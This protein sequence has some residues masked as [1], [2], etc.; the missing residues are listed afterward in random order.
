MISMQ[1]ATFPDAKMPRMSILWN[2]FFSLGTH[3]FNGCWCSC[4]GW[5]ESVN[6]NDKGKLMSYNAIIFSS[7]WTDDDNGYPEMAT[8][9]LEL[10]EQQEW[11]I[12]LGTARDAAL[13]ITVSYWKSLEAMKKME[14]NFWTSNCPE[15]WKR[16]M[17]IVFP[18]TNCKSR[19]WIKLKS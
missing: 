13:G 6:Y 14:S 19:K 1:I 12:G 8:R 16:K 18:H 10:A 2:V 5:F 9:L 4:G 11:F 17:V 7:K 3:Y 15:A